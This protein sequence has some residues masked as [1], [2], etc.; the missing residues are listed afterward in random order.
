MRSF[1]WMVVPAALVVVA[2]DSTTPEEPIQTRFTIG[3]ERP[4]TLIRPLK[5]VAGTPIPVVTVLHGYGGNSGS[6]DQYFGISRRRNR[7]HFAVILSDGTRDR[8]E[9]QFWNATDF[10]CD[11]WGEDPDD[12]GYLNDLVEEATDYVA[13]S[14]V[15]LIGL[16][17]G[18]FMSYRMACESMPK[19]RGIVSL[20]G[21]SFHDAK[22]CEGARP[23]PILHIHGTADATILYNGG[24]RAGGAVR[25][26]GAKETVERWASRAGCD[27]E[28]GDTLESLDLVAD[29]PGAETTPLRYRTGCNTGITVELWTIQ[30]GSHVPAFDSNDIGD[31]LTS[32][33]FG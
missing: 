28:A 29:L 1:K 9:R 4:A 22:R 2:C 31:R 30:D 11:F 25:Y 19:L 17:N 8:D 26:P 5:Y 12:A 27:F 33:L 24:S 10:C 23:L 7:D 21:T 15:Y 32:W 3:G 6:V 20:A 14:G 13:I 18:A 16:S